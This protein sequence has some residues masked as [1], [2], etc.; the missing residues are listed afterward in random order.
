MAQVPSEIVMLARVQ[1]AC[2]SSKRRTA[3]AALD[4]LLEVVPSRAAGGGIRPAELKPPP[5]L[6]LVGMQRRRF[7]LARATWQYI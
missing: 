1:A 6:R 4:T 2:R 7:P 3:M 5:H